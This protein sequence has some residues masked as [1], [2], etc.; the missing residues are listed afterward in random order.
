M[1]FKG[2]ILV[3]K[4]TIV[5]RYSEF[6][7]YPDVHGYFFAITDTGEGIVFHSTN[8]QENVS[9]NQFQINKNFKKNLRSC[10]INKKKNKPEKTVF[11]SSLFKIMK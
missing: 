6:V 2:Q 3:E 9:K 5:E 4:C 7:I 8:S 10:F 11:L 1:P